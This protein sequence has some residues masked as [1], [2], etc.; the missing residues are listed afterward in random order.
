MARFAMMYSTDR[1]GLDRVIEAD[2]YRVNGK[3]FEFLVDKEVVRTLKIDAVLQIR[4]MDDD[5]G[6]AGAGNDD[7][8]GDQTCSTEASLA[9]ISRTEDDALAD[10]LS[11]LSDDSEFE[12]LLAGIP[13]VDRG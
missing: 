13:E 12:R 10:L 6:E 1:Q 9:K 5:E 3:F 8:E 7:E 2:F 11:S 4:R